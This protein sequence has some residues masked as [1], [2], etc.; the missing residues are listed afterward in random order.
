MH[1]YSIECW[2]KKNQVL[3][4]LDTEKKARLFRQRPVLYT[5]FVFSGIVE[6][7]SNC[8]EYNKNIRI[9]CLEGL[10]LNDKYVESIAKVYQ[11]TLIIN[12]S[13]L[14]F[15]IAGNG[16]QRQSQGGQFPAFQ[17]LRQGL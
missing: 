14:M 16:G 9:L 17:Y 4:H 13:L 12:I 7:V 6:A 8:I 15:N 3:E 1:Y 10:P 11:L 2:Q 5:K